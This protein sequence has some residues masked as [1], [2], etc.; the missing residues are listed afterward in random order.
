[1]DLLLSWDDSWTYV[2]VFA[3]RK[4]PLL[5]S[6]PRCQWARLQ[7]EVERSNKRITLESST[8]EFDLTT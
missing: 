2:G 3:F 1:M 6:R 8:L 5:L 7:D 4:G